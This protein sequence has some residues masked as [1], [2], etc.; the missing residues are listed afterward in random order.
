MTIREFITIL[1][2]WEEKD[3]EVYLRFNE[4]TDEA[5]MINFVDDAGVYAVTYENTLL[6]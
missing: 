6:L 2:M 5:E 4:N 1:E 3:A